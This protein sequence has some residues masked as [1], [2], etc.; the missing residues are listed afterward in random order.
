[1]NT[2]EAVNT[3]VTANIQFKKKFDASKNLSMGLIG[4]IY[5]RLFSR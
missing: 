1:M 4:D 3:K 5:K 2:L